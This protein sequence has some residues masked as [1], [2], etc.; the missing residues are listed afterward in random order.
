M[1]EQTMRTV[2][3]LLPTARRC[4][5]LAIFVCVL[6]STASAWIYPE[7]RD[8]TLLAIRKLDPT[9]RAV[10][11]KLWA[12]ARI[13][14]ETR[15]SVFAADTAQGEEPA[16]IDYGAWPAIAGDHSVSGADLLHNVLNTDWIL[17]V[18]DIAAELK[19][20]TAK[21]TERSDRINY[22][23]DSDIKLQRADPAYATRAGKNNVHFLL[24][25]PRADIDTRTYLRASVQKGAE[26]NAIGTYTW[27]HY[28]ALLKAGR[29]SREEL[30][31]KER[32]ELILAGLADEAFSLHFLEDA[33]AAGHITGTWGDASLRKGTHDYYNDHGFETRS[34]LGK[35]M[36]LSGDAWMRPEDAER[37]SDIMSVSLAQFIDAASGTGVGA[38]LVTSELPPATPDTF[39]VGYNTVHLQREY[40]PAAIQL[41]AE[42]LL[43]TPIPALGSG[44]GE[45]PRF[46]A[47][48]GPFIG[49]VSAA[50]AGTIDG[51]FGSG[52]THVG[53]I[54]GLGLAMRVGLGIEGVIN[55]SGDGLVFLDIG[56]RQD[57]A[58]TQNITGTESLEKYGAIT[59]MIPARAAYTLRLRMPFWL[60]PGDLILALPFVAPFS[61]SAYMQM[62]VAAGAGGLIPWQAGIA[63]V[64][65]RFQFMVGREIGVSFFGYGKEED[66][67]FLPSTSET[68][69]QTTVVA[70]RSI[71]LQ[72]PVLEYRPF[73]TFSMDQSSSLVFQLFG[74]VDIP[75]K[76][77]MVSPPEAPVPDHR[78]TWMLGIRVAFDWRYYLGSG[79]GGHR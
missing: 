51:G 32:T 35:P 79:Q 2:P 49:L 33:F 20:R 9:H 14:H 56:V 37:A 44:K 30:S 59:A 52:Q 3:L 61:T 55:E 27:Y 63:T 53:G 4:A 40:D 16:S 22:L 62:A 13:G 34:W 12:E 42:T 50:A 6:V 47:E 41:F 60:I 69:P 5:I 43:E 31:Q 64:I 17:D 25:R 77:T 57:A 75:T 76:V 58:T 73:R 72:F 15:L 10:F 23:R 21:A 38:R 1:L 18:A 67:M 8:I 24:A 7:H 29:L 46:R 70:V 54:G 71:Q 48:L 28:S 39:N 11:G 78:S 74:G 26:L 19:N 45:L 36:I 65:G 68:Y 66:R